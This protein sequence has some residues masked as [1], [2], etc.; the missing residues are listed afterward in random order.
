MAFLKVGD[1]SG[2]LENAVCFCKE[3]LDSCFG[4]INKY[5]PKKIHGFGVNAYWAMERYP[6]FSV[7]ATSWTYAGR[8]SSDYIFTNGRYKENPNK[9]IAH[10]KKK[11]IH[12]KIRTAELLDYLFRTEK[13]ITSLWAARG[14]DWNKIII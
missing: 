7:D 11:K 6:F 14:V 3:W 9:K 2:E 13:T 5:W 8:S 1:N 4:V 12:Y 10:F